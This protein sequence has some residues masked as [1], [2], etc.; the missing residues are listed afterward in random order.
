MLKQGLFIDESGTEYTVYEQAVDGFNRL[1]FC[2]KNANFHT[3]VGSVK[4]S[5][6]KQKDTFIYGDRNIYRSYNELLDSAHQM[7]VR[8]ETSSGWQLGKYY[9]KIVRSQPSSNFLEET[10]Q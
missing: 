7:N 10:V 9:T 5:I 8:S 1:D 2:E 6:V 3:D 4:F